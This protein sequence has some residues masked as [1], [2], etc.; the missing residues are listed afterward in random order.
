[1][2][3]QFENGSGCAIAEP[4]ALS[5]NTQTSSYPNATPE[6][7][8]P[9][10]LQADRGNLKLALELLAAGQCPLPVSPAFPAEKYRAH[11]GADEKPKLDKDGAPLARFTGKNPSFL[12]ADGHP[13]TICHGKYKDTPPTEAELRGMF[14]NPATGIGLLGSYGGVHCIDLDRKDFA[15]Q[16]DCDAAFLAL[17]QNPLLAGA[18]I[19]RTPGG[20]YHILIRLS[21]KPGFTNLSVVEGGHHAGELLGHGRFFVTAPTRGPDGK[22]YETIQTGEPPLIE[23]LGAIGIYKYSSASAKKS[24]PPMVNSAPKPKLTANITP[25]C[26]APIDL[27]RLVTDNTR[28]AIAGDDWKGDRSDTLTTAANDIFGWGNWCQTNNVPLSGDPES[29][30]FDAG[31]ALGLD[32]DRIERIIK[33]ID[34]G[35]AQPSCVMA[36]GDESAWKRVWKLEPAYKPVKAKKAAKPTPFKD[37]DHEEGYSSTPL[38][39]LCHVSFVITGEAIVPRTIQVSGHLKATA[40]TNSEEGADAGLYLEFST[41][42][43]CERTWTMPRRMVGDPNLAITELAA[44]G[45]WYNHDQKKL[46]V[47][48]IVEMGR[49]LATAYTIVQKTGWV[50]GVDGSLSFVLHSETIGDASIRY[51]D[52]EPPAHPLLQ[53]VGV[54]RNWQQTIGAMSAGNSRLLGAIGYALAPPLMKILGIEGGGLHYFGSSS[55]GKTT[56]LGVANSV[57]GEQRPAT[58]NS[59]ANGLDALAEAHSDG[60]YP[61][62]EIGQAL[63]KT[64]DESSYNLA[65]GTGRTR[66]TKELSARK[67]KTWRTLFFSTGEFAMLPFLKTAGIT[68]KGGQEARMPSVPADAGRGLGLFDTIHS[69]ATP[70]EFADELKTQGS[71]NGGT[72]LVAFLEKLVPASSSQEWIDRQKSRHQAI[73]NKLKGTTIDPDGTVGRV[74]R[75]FALI[76]LALELAQEWGVTLFPEGQVEWAVES[77]FTDWIEA[78]GGAGSI[79]IRQAMDRIE[80]LF[81]AQEFGD[82]MRHVTG[83]RKDGIVRNLLATKVGP[84]FLVPPSVF[85]AELAQDVDRRLLIAEMQKRGWLQAPTGNDTRPTKVRRIPGDETSRRVFEFTRFWAGDFEELPPVANSVTSPGNRPGNTPI[86]AHN[87]DTVTVTAPEKLVTGPIACYQTPVTPENRALHSVQP[88][89][90]RV[91]T[92]SGSEEGIE[93]ENKKIFYESDHVDLEPDFDWAVA[94]VVA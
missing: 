1:M 72:A 39:G 20:G 61:I 4:A 44:R 76:Q 26:A 80:A 18:P 30:V 47:K 46:L 2:M 67:I 68:A 3:S 70:Q 75:R 43:G 65:N 15:T 19:D 56:A 23:D 66:M 48:Y 35:A 38:T 60:M 94:G 84:D 9:Q 33:T 27:D 90:Y 54:L 87:L 45:F 83:D 51:L 88:P 8:A 31:R 73:V 59:T 17:Q 36:G 62:D 77:L 22:S 89:C 78:R 24:T 13:M 25:G 29:L 91:T 74:A 63:A 40:H 6:S 7:P 53:R 82:R 71:I 11:P 28:S 21:S 79:D 37:D 50:E 5:T 41:Q 85:D 86:E 81:V 55:T 58:W 69:W 93:N 64:V 42:R 10:P 49:D 14:E 52:V 32:D 57:T 12:N 92:I 34:T 16:E